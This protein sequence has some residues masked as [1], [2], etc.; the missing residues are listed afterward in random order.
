MIAAV[1]AGALTGAII[2]HWL[3]L[4]EA[5]SGSRIVV[6]PSRTSVNRVTAAGLERQDPAIAKGELIPGQDFEER[7]REGRGSPVP[8]ELAVDGLLQD[9]VPADP[10]ERAGGPEGARAGL[11]PSRTRRPPARPRTRQILIVM[12]GGSSSGWITRAGS[13]NSL[14]LRPSSWFRN[15]W[16]AEVSA[17]SAR[18]TRQLPAVASGDRR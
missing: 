13:R 14:V 4:F 18:G 7:V 12:A 16:T 17:C 8:L 9:V 5:L 10:E 2:R 11:G 6:L 3:G 1:S 15:D